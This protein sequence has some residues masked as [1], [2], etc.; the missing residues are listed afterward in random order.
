MMCAVG[1]HPIDVSPPGWSVDDGMSDPIDAVVSNDQSTSDMPELWLVSDSDDVDAEIGIVSGQMGYTVVLAQLLD[2]GTHRTHVET[3]EHIEGSFEEAVEYATGVASQLECG[4]RELRC[5]GSIESADGSKVDFVAVTV[6]SCPGDIPV[7]ELAA[8]VMDD[9]RT[10][11]NDGRT[12]A[13]ANGDCGT[14]AETFD[15]T[16][17]VE[18]AE[19]TVDEMDP[20]R[21]DVFPKYEPDVTFADSE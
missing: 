15:G 12:I 9:L 20:V 8:V 5:L 11:Q 13:I 1:D 14:E 16:V 18:D 3:R 2:S 7:S 10:D 21:I 17:T 6:G 19:L 4:A